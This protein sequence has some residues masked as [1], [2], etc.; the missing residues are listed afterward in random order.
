MKSHEPLPWLRARRSHL[1]ATALACAIAALVSAP[2]AQAKDGVRNLGGGLEQLAAPAVGAQAQSRSLPAA[3]AEEDLSFSPAAQFDDAGRALVRISLDGKKPAAAVLE[4]LRSTA[5]VEVVA[6]DL[7]YAK[8]VVEAYVPVSA[9]RSVAGKAGVLAVVPSAPMVTNVGATT[10]QGVVQHRVNQLPDGVDGSGITV[11]VISDSYNTFG[12]GSAEADLATGD[13]PGP[14]NPI[15]SQ[16]VVVLQDGL[17]Q[18]DIDEGRAMIQIVHDM[19]PKARLGFATAS[20][21]QLNFADNIRSLAGVPGSP[22][23]VA[24][25]KADVIV[26]DVIYPD[27]PMFQDGIIAQAVDEVVARGVSYFSSAGNRP[28][29]QAYD[30]K[31]RIVPGVAASWAGT[32]L[33]FATV[34]PDLYAGGFHDF[35]AD[36]GAIDIAQTVQF[37][38]GNTF[39][40]QWNEPFDP[41]PPT[42]VGDPIVQGSGTVPPNGD[43]RFTFNGTAGQV[44]EIF[45]DADPASATPNPDLTLALL[46]P[47][48]NEIDFVDTGTNPESLTLELPETGTYT[49]VVDS[50]LPAQFGGYI[51]RVQEVEI[52]EQVLSDYNILFFLPNGTFIGALAEQ[53]RFTNRPIE[54]GGIPA[55]TLQVVV[56]RANVPAENRNVADRIRY[57]GFGGVNPQEYFSYLDPVTYGHNSAAGANG[58]AA[59]AFFPPFVPESFTSPGPSTIY[60]D[61]NN[62]RFKHPQIRLKPDMAAMDGANT[63]FFLQD[64]STDPDTFPNFFGTSAAAPHAAAVAALVLDAAGGPGSV[65]PNRMRKILQD[66]AFRHDL[67]PYFSS[68]FALTLGNALAITAQ[69]DFANV[70]QFDPNVF[71]LSHIGFR[72]LESFHIN[73]SNADATQ[74]P[75]GV[76]FDERPSVGALLGQP[77]VIGNRTVGLDAADITASFSIPADPPAVAGQWKQLDLAFA[78]GSFRS[79]DR[80]SFGVDRD[81]Q[82]QA[83][84]LNG[85]A[86]GNSADLLGPTVRIPEGTIATG[87]AEFFGSFQGGT[88]FRGRFFNLIGKG[89]SQLDGF[90]F[91]NAEAAVKAVSSKK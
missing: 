89:Y 11:G 32:N 62:K 81:E 37:A 55:T 72:A 17:S 38:A 22:H 66:S 54:I 27:E 48:G 6:S 50:F 70:G 87:A 3:T 74:V 84:T 83:G 63:T 31:V 30:S 53:N 79:G 60:F 91:V 5:N 46:D 65:S 78:A 34:P 39:V 76:I 56:A 77:F 7:S 44:V 16:P 59:Y 28:A 86:G 85:A 51:Y 35:N 4:S 41:I 21:G 43:D 15:N 88:P 64:S 8:G 40:F 13:V 90:G 82:D 58:V 24:G 12:A 52:T 57:V 68:G 36:S 9:L 20:G 26:D 67:D 73:G 75:P 14:G 29:T 33:N 47:D 49:V 25:F 18:S 23:A 42:P 2:P 45:V 61:K 10:S 71:T 69:S 19:A 80:L 1:G